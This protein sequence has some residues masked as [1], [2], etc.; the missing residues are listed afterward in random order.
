MQLQFD[1]EYDMWKL[2]E[3]L[4]DPNVSETVIIGGEIITGFLFA[5]SNSDWYKV[6]CEWHLTVQNFQV[7]EMSKISRQG[8]NCVHESV[9]LK[10][11]TARQKLE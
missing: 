5:A 2:N 9:I 3:P 10:L 11:D 6:Q 7:S 4:E 1:N 8:Q